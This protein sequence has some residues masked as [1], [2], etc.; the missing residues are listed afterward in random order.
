MKFSKSMTLPRAFYVE[1]CKVKLLGNLW[2]Q[3][4]LPV[5]HG[6]EPLDVSAGGDLIH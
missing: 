1:A 4:E 6:R 5:F 3:E 2:S